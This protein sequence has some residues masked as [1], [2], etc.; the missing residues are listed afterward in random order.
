MKADY[1]KKVPIGGDLGKELERIWEAI[2]QN[3]VQQN[4]K[5]R[6]SRTPSGTTIEPVNSGDET[7]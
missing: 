4:S 3:Q 5:V 6:V 7:Q 1:K 2:R